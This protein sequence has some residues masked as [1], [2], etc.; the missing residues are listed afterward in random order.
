[1]ERLKYLFFDLD[2]TLLR[3]DKS[4][5]DEALAYLPDLKKRKD[6]RYGIATGRAW[7]AIEPLIE[8]FGLDTLFD[9]IVMD[10]GSEIYDLAE[11][12]RERLGIIQT[13]QMKQLLDAFGGY[14]FLAVAFHNPKGFF[15]TKISYRTERVLINNR[16]SGYHDPY[17]EEFE[18]TARVMLLFLIEDQ[19][20]VLEAVRR[21]PVPGIHG[22]LS[23]PEVY[24][25]LCEGVS[26]AEGIRHYVTANGDRIEQ[27]VVFGDSENDLEMIQKCGVSVSMKNGT[28]AVRAAADYVTG[29]TNNEDGVFRFLKEHE[30]WFQEG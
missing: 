4:I 23:E 30:D 1:M 27:T 15:T 24:D 25:F 3:D 7:T 5:S 28:E 19:E 9:V 2:M 18:A 6:V 16:L 10:N 29:Y 8:R 12:R 22:M 17:K 13:E 21:H 26:K 20:R 14:D 11:G